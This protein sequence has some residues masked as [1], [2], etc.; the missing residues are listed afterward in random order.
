MTAR[1]VWL[2]EHGRCT[3]EKLAPDCPCPNIR[4]GDVGNGRALL[5]EHKLDAEQSQWP[6]AALALQYP[7]PDGWWRQRSAPKAPQIDAEP[8]SRDPV[9]FAGVYFWS[10]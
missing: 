8:P 9:A 1:F 5:A 3:A 4:S 7:A 10:V 6:I 2:I